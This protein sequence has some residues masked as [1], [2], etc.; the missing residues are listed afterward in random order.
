M[1]I[2]VCEDKSGERRQ[3]ISDLGEELIRRKMNA[4]V[5]SYESGEALLSAAA[6]IPF[7]IYFL[8]ILMPGLN[9]MD[10]AK[11]L[12]SQNPEAAIVFIT[13]S[14]DYLADGFE[15]GAVHYLVKPYL[16]TDLQEAMN[17]CLR[18]V[19]EGE[20]YIELMINRENQRILLSDLLW[21][22]SKDKVCYL[23]LKSGERRSYLRLDELELLLDDTRYLRC[24]RS[25]IVNLDYVSG[26]NH[27]VFLLPEGKEVPMRQAE[28]AHFRTE[29]ENYL[30]E[31]MRRR[32]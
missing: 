3:L 7:R 4:Q 8:D 5:M 1:H 21:A 2:A 16:K 19:K 28:R 18:Q 24:H 29:Y 30:F 13:S 25:F 15:V 22:E 6:H 12:R 20:R 17:R 26:T 10:V 9:G 32:Q 14:R 11:T 23:H 31:K 27:G